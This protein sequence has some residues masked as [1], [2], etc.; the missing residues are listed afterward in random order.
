MGVFAFLHRVKRHSS[1]QFALFRVVFGL[2][3]TWHFATL[4]PWA[5]EL[6]SAQGV[7]ADPTLSPLH[8]IF[9]N[10]LVWIGAPSF[11]VAWCVLG[12]VLGLLL[13]L[14]WRR[15]PVCL[16]LW[17]VWAALF[18]RNP[19]IANPS[20][21]YVGMMLILMALV[22]DGEALRWRGR[23]RAP[24]RPWAMPLGV[25]AAAWLLMAVGYTFS[26]LE[27]LQ[28][29]SWLDGSA[30]THVLQNPLA[31]LGPLRDWALSLPGWLHSVATWGALAAETL[32]LPLSLSSRGRKWAWSLLAA[33]HLG[34]LA[35]LDFGSISAGMLLLHAFTFDPSWLP[36][37]IERARRPL[38]LFDGECGLCNGVVRFL[39]REDGWGQLR[40]APLQGP[41][42]QALLKRL[43]LPTADFDTIVFMPDEAGEVFYLRSRG[44]LAALDGLGGLW[45]I[46]AWLGYLVPGPLRDGV[47]RLVAALRYRLF[48][49]NQSCERPEPGWA[50]RVLD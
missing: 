46:V 12:A 27:K 43:G 18:N 32:F 13:A 2:W 6:F 28:S 20:I 23:A 4:A 34:L 38:L 45:R 10:P 35:V 40:F 24:G 50:E 48:G 25:Y 15:V 5:A 39:L 33:M 9:P 37:R 29:P 7:L 17:L 49:P 16:A 42:A 41:T 8:G 22:P 31:R 44:V 1:G 26:G 47:Y 36:A 11:A 14:G 3:L 30:F 19:L 21:P